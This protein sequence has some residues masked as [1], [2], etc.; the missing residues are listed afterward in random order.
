MLRSSPPARPRSSLQPWRSASRLK[1]LRDIYLVRS[2]RG[3]GARPNNFRARACRGPKPRDIY[4]VRAAFEPVAE[5]NLSLTAHLRAVSQA[6]AARHFHGEAR[7]ATGGRGGRERGR[8]GEK[9]EAHTSGYEAVDDLA[10]VPAGVVVDLRSIISP[11][12]AG[13]APAPAAS[14]S[15]AS[16]HRR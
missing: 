1:P 6:R 2:E 8:G 13:V 10:G 3:G 5:L 12:A 7:V 16:A 15:A 4:L 9:R 11:S 14:A